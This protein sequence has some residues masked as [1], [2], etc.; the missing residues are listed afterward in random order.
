M[1]S[2][3]FAPIT[4]RSEFF[5]LRSQAHNE[6][7]WR[8]HIQILSSC[9]WQPHSAFHFFRWACQPNYV[10]QGAERGERCALLLSPLRPSFKKPTTDVIEDGSQFTMFLTAPLLAFCQLIGL[11]FSDEDYDVYNDVN[12][13]ISTSF[14]EWEVM[15]CTT[16][17]LDLVWAQVLCDPFLR[18]LI[19]RFIFCR[20]VLTLFCLREESD[21]YLPV[22]I[23]ELPDSFSPVSEYVQPT[24]RRLANHLNVADS[25]HL[26]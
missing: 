22:C 16:P 25:F 2:C 15:L 26:Y 19:L 5:V 23:P 11:K 18:R 4:I 24:I 3:D 17:S 9:S 12:A 13:I 1:S 8:E 20:A 21:Q 7:C 14:S 6:E 10:L